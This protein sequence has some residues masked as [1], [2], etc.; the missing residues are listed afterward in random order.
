LSNKHDA[1]DGGTLA[2][3]GLWVGIGVGIFLVIAFLVPTPQTLI[4]TLEKYGYVQ[5]MIAWEIAHNVNK[6]EIFS[7]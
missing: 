6:T 5:K 7:R 2:K 4:E 3:K 1:G